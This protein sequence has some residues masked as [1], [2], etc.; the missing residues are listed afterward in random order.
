LCGEIHRQLNSTSAN[1]VSQSVACDRRSNRI[2]VTTVFG[3]IDDIVGVIHVLTG[4]GPAGRTTSL[5]YHLWQRGLGFFQFGE[6]SAV[7]MVAIVLV[8]LATWAQFRLLSRR[9]HYG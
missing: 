2:A 3:V 9:V 1:E 6:A 7:A 8:L 4:G 5:V